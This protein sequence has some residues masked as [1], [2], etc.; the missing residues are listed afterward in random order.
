MQEFHVYFLSQ[1]HQADSF[2]SDLGNESSIFF[3]L[4]SDELCYKIFSI[5]FSYSLRLRIKYVSQIIMIL[6]ICQSHFNEGK[7]MHS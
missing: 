2:V 1:T 3:I 7:N 5:S 4:C 6:L